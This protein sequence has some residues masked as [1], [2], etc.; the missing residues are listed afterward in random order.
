MDGDVIKLGEKGC[1][2]LNLLILVCL[3]E[4]NVVAFEG[5]VL[6]GLR[7]LKISY[8]E[9]LLRIEFLAVELVLVWGNLLWCLVLLLMVDWHS[10]SWLLVL[11][12]L[13]VIVLVGVV[14]YISSHS[15][16]FSK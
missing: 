4:V 9:S 8:L 15:C 7:C 6:W 3:R 12:V 5:Y 13:L 10:L 1:S 16:P 2:F 11:L 14:L